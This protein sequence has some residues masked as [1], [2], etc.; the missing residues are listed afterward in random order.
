MAVRHTVSGDTR[1]LAFVLVGALVLYGIIAYVALPSA[2]T[3]YEHQKRLAGLPMVTRTVQG[4]AGD[5]LNVG[6]V[7]AEEDVLCAM[8]AANWYPADPITWRSSLRIIGSVLLHRPYPSAPVSNLLYE[9]RR[10]DL[11]FEKPFGRSASRRH[12]VRFWQVLASGE[13]ARP[14][15]L[16]AATYDRGVGL[17]HYTGQVTHRIAP[18]VDAERDALTAD[19]VNARVVKAIYQVSGI[20]PTLRGRN[21]EGNRFYTDGELKISRLVGGCGNRADST[22]RL[23]DPPLVKFH[24][25]IWSNVIKQLQSDDDEAGRGGKP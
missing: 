10:E 19:L 1:R 3:H 11:A 14:V 23:E 5:P 22:V 12:H 15:W 20:G 6:L 4:M 16:G 24:D 17:S 8:H 25:A 9:G 21:G 18:D 2:W 13:E 7:G